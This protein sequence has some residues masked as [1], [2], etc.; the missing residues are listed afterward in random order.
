MSQGEERRTLDRL[1][2][3]ADAISLHVPLTDETRDFVDARALAGAK[4]GAYLVN[5]SRGAV[6]DES[7]LLQALETG[8]LAGTG[9]D[10][11]AVEPPAPA[12][13]LLRHPCPRD[14]ALSLVAEEAMRDLQRF[15]AK[16]IGPRAGR[17][18]AA[19]AADRDHARR[20]G[21]VRRSSGSPAASVAE[22]GTVLF[23]RRARHAGRAGQRG[24]GA[25]TAGRVGSAR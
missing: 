8:R 2:A 14:A 23:G 15:L 6:V 7:A 18:G 20:P 9:L 4:R 1:P 25:G 3:E 21:R 12:H 13:P 22:D 10:V 19:G 5:T 17:V 11:L 24:G 16:D